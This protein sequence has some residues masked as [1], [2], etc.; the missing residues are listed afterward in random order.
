MKHGVMDAACSTH[1]TKEN[2]YKMFVET[3]KERENYEDLDKNGRFLTGLVESY[4]SIK[5]L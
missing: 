4:C 5:R 2:S 3:S 1:K